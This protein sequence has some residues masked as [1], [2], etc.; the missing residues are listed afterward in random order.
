MK[1][2]IFPLAEIGIFMLYNVFPSAIRTA[3]GT[4]GPS[5]F[6]HTFTFQTY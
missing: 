6:G 5:P 2:C 3:A 1:M 4:L